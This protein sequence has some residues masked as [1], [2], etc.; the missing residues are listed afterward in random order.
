MSKQKN[1]LLETLSVC[2]CV[3]ML[4]ACNGAPESS[5]A[6]STAST[7][8]DSDSSQVQS[9]PSSGEHRV[10]RVEVFDRGLQHTLRSTT[11]N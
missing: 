3:A 2:L 11:T 6:V 10:L 7:P 5:S 9:S 4:S 8:S 1:R